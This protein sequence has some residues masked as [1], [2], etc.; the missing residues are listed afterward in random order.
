MHVKFAHLPVFQVVT[1]SSA[2]EYWIRVFYFLILSPL[3]QLLASPVSPFSISVLIV[4]SSDQL[5]LPQGRFPPPSQSDFFPPPRPLFQSSGCP[6]PPPRSALY[7]SIFFFPLSSSF[8]SSYV[9]FSFVLGV[10]FLLPPFLPSLIFFALLGC[11]SI[12]PGLQ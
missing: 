8:F 11:L 4:F 3:Q 6:S 5:Y 2:G 12:F 7:L 9:Q 1:L 10:F